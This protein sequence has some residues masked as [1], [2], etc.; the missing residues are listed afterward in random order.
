MTRPPRRRPAARVRARGF[1]G[2][3][4]FCAFVLPVH[5]PL[6]PAAA[7]AQDGLPTIDEMPL[8]TAA[9]L[10]GRT[11][12]DWVVLNS[13]EVIEVRSLEP[14]P[15]TLA[16]LQRRSD[17]VGRM[18]SQDADARK[19]A[20]ARYLA[21]EPSDPPARLRDDQLREYRAAYDALTDRE[22]RRAVRD[23]FGDARA[24]ALAGVGGEAL[25]DQA[26]VASRPFLV[27]RGQL[28]EDLNVAVLDA[29]V[30]DPLFAIETYKVER[31]V[32]HE[33]LMLRRA[34]ELLQEG[35]MRRAYELLFALERLPSSERLPGGWPGLREKLD[36]AALIDVD[37]LLDAG[38]NENALGRAEVL[39]QR[40]PDLIPAQDRLAEAATRLFR[41]GFDAG[42]YRRA[43][44]F[45]ARLRAAAPNHRA[46]GELAGELSA[47]A[48]RRLEDALAAER[49]GDAARAADRARAA[50][51]VDPD[52]AEVRRAFGR[53][54]RRYQVLT[55]GAL[56]GPADPSSE[57]PPVPAD[58]G[59][60]PGGA[61]G[62]LPAVRGRPV[63]RL[64]ALPQ[65]VLLEGWEPTDLGRRAAFR[66]RP[67]FPDWL[68][69]PPLS[70]ADVLA[71]LRDRLDPASPLHD[72]RLA[73]EIAGVRQLSAR[74]FEVTFARVPLS[75]EAVLAAPVLVVPPDATSATFEVA[76]KTGN[77]GGD[78]DVRVELRTPY[79]PRAAPSADE[80][81]VT[82][83][84]RAVPQPADAAPRVAEIRERAYPDG[85]S[86][87]QGWNR[88][89]FDVLVHPRPWDAAALLGDEGLRN[90]KSSLP[91]THAI[92]INPAS[93]PLKNAE[94]RRALL[95]AL[96]RRA[97][98]DSAVL[99]VEAAELPSADKERLRGLGRVV[100]G[101][102]ASFAEATN[103]LL[104]PK[105]QDLPLAYALALA[106]GKALAK[107][108]GESGVPTLTLLAPDDAVVAAVVGEVAAT[109]ERVGIALDVVVG[110]AAD[111][112]HAEGDW[113]LAYRILRLREPGREIAPL[114]TDS[115]DVTLESL[116]TVSD[117]LRRDL[118]ALERAGDRNTA[119]A[120]LH[121]LHRHV[122]GEGRIV[123]L[124]EVDEYVFTR[125]AVRG[126]EGRLVHPY[127]GVARWEVLEEPPADDFDLPGSE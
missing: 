91:A 10:L 17:F 11:P 96:D 112:R 80:P 109:W 40:A 114:L 61:A 72:E 53:L 43:R 12:T 119:V 29:A 104:T 117:W 92:Q 13:D 42:D 48:G 24:D 23:L 33:D 99:R 58:A 126:P 45:L 27:E 41:A 39:L 22:L 110:D 82:V 85:P 89:E 34:E 2:A 15:D 73:E 52:D 76:A 111:R 26:V 18:T 94:L 32:H 49:D 74:D 65:S 127:Q 123:P 3:V 81:G 98:L 14:R 54:T 56:G 21:G 25:K 62:G 7:R 28:L 36:R 38:E 100:S 6:A 46:V 4:F 47:E 77:G 101:P 16:E 88:G 1:A 90:A 86:L 107:D 102:F 84:R 71:G 70:A 113:D 124:F 125:P 51:R 103:P 50:A 68:P 83:Y 108:G 118:I 122:R 64:A 9:D 75:T 8:P 59:G 60:R 55:A 120:L 97:I 63:R 31:V 69:Q 30:D 121:D 115:E 67:R 44:F 79:F 5:V 20:F 105:P 78:G 66:L 19:V 93:A 87:M 95:L 37:E 106:A 35:D 116:L 57:Y